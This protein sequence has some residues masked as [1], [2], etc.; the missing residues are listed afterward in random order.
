MLD[1]TSE[2]DIT[3]LKNYLNV[4]IRKKFNTQVGMYAEEQSFA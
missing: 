4:I 3:T 2:C 1:V